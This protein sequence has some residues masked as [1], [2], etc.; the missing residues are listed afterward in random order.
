MIELFKIIKEMYDLTCI[1]HFDFIEIS[2]D[3]TR[4]RGNKCKLTQHQCHYT[5]P[6]YT[7]MEPIM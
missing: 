3:S 2:E 6:C 4:I 5:S 7:H 1:S